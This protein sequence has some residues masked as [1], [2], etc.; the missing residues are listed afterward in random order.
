MEVRVPGAGRR[1]AVTA[2]HNR[3]H[4][5][6]RCKPLMSER[7]NNDQS[8]FWIHLEILL[9]P[10]SRSSRSDD[11]SAEIQAGRKEKAFC[12]HILG[13]D[14]LCV[15]CFRRS[16][17][18]VFSQRSVVHTLFR[19][20]GSVCVFFQGSDSTFCLQV[21]AMQKTAHVRQ[22][23][24][25]RFEFMRSLFRTAPARS[26]TILY[27]MSASISFSRRANCVSSGTRLEACF[28]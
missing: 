13:R 12:D 17:A 8:G 28:M 22:G 1:P 15:L 23:G 26:G 11:L 25:H 21:R 16:A 27:L 3:R 5:E 18:S 20:A 4:T 9:L 14:R 7:R 19:R 24:I 6:A 10:F 2:G